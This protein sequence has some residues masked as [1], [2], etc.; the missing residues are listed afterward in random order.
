MKEKT[1]IVIKIL[2]AQPGKFL[3]YIDIVD[4]REKAKRLGVNFS[5][6]FEN[7]EII[8]DGMTQKQARILSKALNQL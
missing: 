8:R 3:F 7:R 6:S 4:N 1:Y 2:S 5:S